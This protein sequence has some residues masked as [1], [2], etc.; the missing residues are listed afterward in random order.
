MKPLKIHKLKPKKGEGLRR[1]LSKKNS[2]KTLSVE[3]VKTMKKQR[4]NLSSSLEEI[5]E[6]AKPNS[7]PKKIK[8]L[9]SKHS[10]KHEKNAKKS[11]KPKDTK[12]TKLIS[13]KDSSETE[14]TITP[15]SKEDKMEKKV[16]FSN[17]KEKQALPGIIEIKE[18]DENQN[19]EEEELY[20]PEDKPKTPNSGKQTNLVNEYVEYFE[21]NKP[22][23]NDRTNFVIRKHLSMIGMKGPRKNNSVSFFVDDLLPKAITARPSRTEPQPEDEAYL[24]RSSFYDDSNFK[25]LMQFNK[26]QSIVLQ[27]EDFQLNN[28]TTNIGNEEAKSPPPEKKR[29]IFK[30]ASRRRKIKNRHSTSISSY[31]DKDNKN[32]VSFTVDNEQTNKKFG[33]VKRKKS[34]GSDKL[35][36]MKSSKT[37]VRNKKSIKSENGASHKKSISK[38]AQGKG[39]K[40]LGENTS[41][42]MKKTIEKE[43]KEKKESIAQQPIKSP[44]V[45]D[46]ETE[47]SI[48]EN[49]QKELSSDQI[50]IEKKYESAEET[51]SER[52]K[53]M[54]TTKK[55]VNLENTEPQEDQAEKHKNQ[56]PNEINQAEQMDTLFLNHKKDSNTTQASKELMEELNQQEENRKKENINKGVKAEKD[57]SKEIHKEERTKTPVKK[58]TTDNLYN[59]INETYNLVKGNTWHHKQFK[60]E[61]NKKKGSQLCVSTDNNASVTNVEEDPMKAEVD[62]I[63]KKYL[64]A[65]EKLH[66]KKKSWH[67]FD[68]SVKNSNVKVN[69]INMFSNIE[70]TTCFN[71]ILFF[72]DNYR[73]KQEKYED[74][75]DFFKKTF[76]KQ[77]FELEGVQAVLQ[78]FDLI[79]KQLMED[80]G[81]YTIEPYFTDSVLEKIKNYEI[82]KEREKRRLRRN[83]VKGHF[84][85]RDQKMKYMKEMGLLDV[86][87]GS[88]IY[89]AYDTNTITYKYIKGIY[90][91]R[92]YNETPTPIFLLKDW[93]NQQKLAIF[94][95]KFD[96]LKRRKAIRLANIP[97]VQT[98]QQVACCLSGM[99]SCIKNNCSNFMG[100]TL[101]PSRIGATE[102]FYEGFICNQNQNYIE[103]RTTLSMQDMSYIMALS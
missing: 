27:N 33:R 103:K 41:L 37:T 10:L 56:E 45:P 16:S 61:K 42:E 66:K 24:E 19:F 80:L 100:F 86:I 44:D 21:K 8:H 63:I 2:L 95:Q 35:K 17:L 77:Y 14:V 59:E 90:L 55:E 70:P 18:D 12:I 51:V 85:S 28:F 7:K 29:K 67:L 30:S 99:F 88:D 36:S 79:I 23:V 91:N 60:K 82:D 92:N 98:N 83:L 72:M 20:E 54:K 32:R 96:E 89:D 34:S 13:H 43:L 46:Q 1:R 52:L 3:S 71:D 5:E 94:K 101:P 9:K 65:K 38:G 53:K 74:V 57:G 78:I 4:R 47:S 50:K 15:K 62:M 48:K 75:F 73:K 68:L 6:K 93:K 69:T 58:E 40:Q 76:Q 39:K 49:V 11:K 97:H 22:S 26:A 81:T 31:T 102:Q 87:M 64:V 84:R 25:S